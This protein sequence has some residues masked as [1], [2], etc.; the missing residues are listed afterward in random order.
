MN[1]VFYFNILS[2]QLILANYLDIV[3]GSVE[4][5]NITIF[6]IGQISNCFYQFTVIFLTFNNDFWK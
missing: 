4:Y 6:I 2:E 3:E 1:I 5:N